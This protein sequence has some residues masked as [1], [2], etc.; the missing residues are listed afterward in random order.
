MGAVA[1]LWA[2]GWGAVVLS[3]CGSS[4]ASTRAVIAAIVA[5]A[6]TAGSIVAS[7]VE[8]AT[9]AIVGPGCDGCRVRCGCRLPGGAGRPCTTESLSGGGNLFCGVDGV[10][11][12]DLPRDNMLH[13]DRG[14]LG[15]GGDRRGGCG[16]LAGTVSH[17]RRGPGRRII[18]HARCGSQAV[19]CPDGLVADDTQSRRR[20]AATRLR[21]R[22]PC[23]PSGTRSPDVDGTTG[24]FLGVGCIGCSVG[25]RGPTR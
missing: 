3:W 13:R 8:S 1:C 7:R 5:L 12:C 25:R 23:R 6:A 16:A 22:R 18:G 21:R 19:D 9:A 20:Q 17:R 24:R 11:P 14:V 10:A 2:A 4:P 15:D